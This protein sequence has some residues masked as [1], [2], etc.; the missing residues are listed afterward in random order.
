MSVFIDPAFRTSQTV[1]LY[2]ARLREGIK[3]GSSYRLNILEGSESDP[4]SLEYLQSLERQVYKKLD[5][6]LQRWAE[7][8]GET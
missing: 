8:R 7:P 1:S 3:S 2:Q 5:E 4:T 6:T